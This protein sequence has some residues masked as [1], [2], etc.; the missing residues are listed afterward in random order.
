MSIWI[1]TVGFLFLVFVFRSI[2]KM[3]EETGDGRILE[4][5]HEEEIYDEYDDDEQ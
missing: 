1:L 5:E 2:Q 4:M 3:R